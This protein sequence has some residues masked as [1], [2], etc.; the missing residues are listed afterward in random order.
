M[1]LFSRFFEKKSTQH[2]STSQTQVK[3]QAARRGGFEEPYCSDA[4]YST[5][6]RTITSILFGGTSGHCHF[7]Q[8]KVSVTLSSDVK[9]I[10][11]RNAFIF[12]CPS[13]EQRGSV[14]VRNIFECCMCGISLTDEAK[15]KRVEKIGKA[16]TQ[17][18]LP[19]IL[20]VADMNDEEMLSILKRLCVAYMDND[21]L[22]KKLEPIATEIGEKLDK[23]GGIAE[24]RRIFYALG[25]ILGSSTLEMHWGGIGDWRG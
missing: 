2:S 10:P 22:Y 9:L 23:R 4:C 12:I 16:E 7:C 14:Y 15:S 25:G 13:C 3:V 5:A 21:P 20:D 6:G 24:M 8:Q 19:T 1:G 18:S 17:E 11:Y